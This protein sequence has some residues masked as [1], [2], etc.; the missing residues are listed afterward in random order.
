MT[1]VNTGVAIKA[2]QEIDSETDY[3]KYFYIFLCN[4]NSNLVLI[5]TIILYFM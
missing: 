2:H 3:K 5:I 4:R 1:V